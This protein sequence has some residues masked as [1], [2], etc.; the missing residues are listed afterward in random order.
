MNFLSLL[1]SVFI[2]SGLKSITMNFSPKTILAVSQYTITFSIE[3]S[4]ASTSVVKIGFPSSVQITDSTSVPCTLSSIYTL[5]STAGCSVSNR[6]YT[7]T[8]VFGSSGTAA[9][10]VFTISI[11]LPSITNPSTTQKTTPIT[12]ATYTA[13]N[14]LIESITTSTALEITA[15][16]AFFTSAVIT[17]QSNIVGD[18][19]TWVFNFTTNYTIPSGGSLQIKFP[20]WNSYIGATG[21]NGLASI[22]TASNPVCSGLSN[23]GSGL[24]GTF[25][26]ST[27]LLTITGG[28]SSSRTGT[29]SFSVGGILNP[30]TPDA[31]S[32]FYIY[33][34]DAN[35]YS[36]LTSSSLSVQVFTPNKI[37]IDS[38]YIFFSNQTVSTSTSMLVAFTNTN[39]TYAGV[40]IDIRIPSQIVFDATLVLTGSSGIATSLSYTSLG[41][42]TIRIANGFSGY[43]LPTTISIQ[44]TSVITPSN[45]APT[46]VFV[47]STKTPGGNVIDFGSGASIQALPGSVFS[48]NNYV[49]AADLTVGAT[50]TYYFD[51]ILSHSLPSGA[52]LIIQ[53]PNEITIASRASNYPCTS[54]MRGLSQS[55]TCF[56]NSQVLQVLGGFSSGFTSGGVKFGIDQVTNP[57]TTATSSTFQVFTATTNSSGYYIDQTTSDIYF[58]AMP[59]SL[60]SASV[61]PS[62]LITGDITTYTFLIT[63]KNTIPTSGYILVNFPSGVTISDSINAQN[64]CLGISGFPSSTIICTATSSSLTVYGFVSGTFPPGVLQWSI[65]YIMN[66]PS[67]A[68]Y[69]S[70]NITTCDQFGYFIDQKASGIAVQ[71][72]TPNLLSYV[73]ITTES[74]VNA[75]SN[76][77]N[78]NIVVTNPTPNNAYLII[79]APSSIKF[80][81]SPSCTVVS[82]LTGITCSYYNSSAIQAI[83]SF[84]TSRIS[85]GSTINFNALN[86]MN[87]GTTQASTS[88]YVSSF[89]SAGYKIDAK[90]TGITVQTTTPANITTIVISADNSKI[91]ATTSYTISY[92]PVS[93][94]PIG[95]IIFV[96]IPSEFLLGTLTCTPITV[97]SSLNLLTNGNTITIK[98]GFPVSVAAA[99]SVSFKIN[100]ITNPSSQITTSA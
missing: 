53:F 9:P 33:V 78:F 79:V 22:I 26:S 51:L 89:T 24:T 39:P 13:S 29:V 15:T 31:L 86:V 45:T 94:Y 73:S 3:Q 23:I 10:S 12:L 44:F 77:Y 97:S 11:G 65:N 56:V 48:V 14:T 1:L 74:F 87:P 62:S 28:F 93:P 68:V 55:A 67:T 49:T 2:A 61:T 81:N 60:I 19:A 70:F 43:S 42:N 98:E 46:D 50:T 91:A 71:V 52:A 64:T 76:S 41:N 30:P 75:A 36:Y 32:D 5:A 100:N 54:I 80:P 25:S 92:L 4:T 84:S 38:T 99:S 96:V 63:T 7:V 27:N 69:S 17:P 85:S 59:A 40:L 90:F 88:F 58:T 66:P 20:Y 6:V 21:I 37:T 34:L 57:S 47:I 18:S 16:A 82:G 8:G 35:S 95:T 83:L 72:T